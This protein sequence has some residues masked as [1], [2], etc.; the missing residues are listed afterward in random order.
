MTT[1]T[2]AGDLVDRHLTRLCYVA[3]GLSEPARA[4]LLAAVRRWVMSA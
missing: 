4:E 1:A 2:P 3:A